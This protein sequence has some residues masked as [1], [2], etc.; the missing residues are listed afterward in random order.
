M[1]FSSTRNRLALVPRSEKIFMTPIE[2]LHVKIFFG[3]R[4]MHQSIS[5]PRKPPS[6]KNQPTWSQNNK[7][8]KI[9]FFNMGYHT[10]L[11]KSLHKTR[12]N[13]CT[14]SFIMVSSY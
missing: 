6:T 1:G 9:D 14:E 13:N 2:V 4:N 8:E 3:P 11:E 12:K 10:T 7:V 5:R